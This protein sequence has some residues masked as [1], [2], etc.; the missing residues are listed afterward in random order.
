[1]NDNEQDIILLCLVFFLGLKSIDL[2]LTKAIQNTWC[3]CPHKGGLILHKWLMFLSKAGL[4]LLLL[5]SY[6]F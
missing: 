1:M 4:L 6:S 3:K 2:S 5:P